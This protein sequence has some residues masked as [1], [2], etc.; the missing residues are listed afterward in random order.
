MD[1]FDIEELR[2][3][4]EFLEDDKNGEEF[5]KWLMDESD[6]AFDDDFCTW[7]TKRKEKENEGNNLSSRANFCG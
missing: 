2:E 5:G 7:M 3:F 4:L 6:A 1:Q